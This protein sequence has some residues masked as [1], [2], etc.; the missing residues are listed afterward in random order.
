MLFVPFLILAQHVFLPRLLLLTRI[1][2]GKEKASHALKRAQRNIAQEMRCILAQAS[3]FSSLIRA[4]RSRLFL[5]IMR[6]DGR[7]CLALTDVSAD[8]G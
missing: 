1:R 3:R 6:L 8:R 5:S 4:A 7:Y 2:L